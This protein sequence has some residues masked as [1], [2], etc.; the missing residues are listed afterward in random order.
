MKRAFHFSAKLNSRDIQ[1]CNCSWVTSHLYLFANGDRR[2][3]IEIRNLYH[4]CYQA[5][6]EDVP[7]VHPVPVEFTY[8]VRG[9]GIITYNCNWSVVGGGGWRGWGRI[10]PPPPPPPP[11]KTKQ[12]KTNKPKKQNKSSTVLS[13]PKFGPPPPPPPPIKNSWIRPCFGCSK[14][15]STHF[16][17]NQSARAC[18]VCSNKKNPLFTIYY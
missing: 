4:F 7:R 16:Q 9:K 18:V 2:A 15:N 13:Q 17:V 11:K 5:Q 3:Q 6:E 1:K 10:Y 8:T 14:A 12:N